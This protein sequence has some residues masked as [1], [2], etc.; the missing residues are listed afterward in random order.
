MKGCEGM[1]CDGAETEQSVTGGTERDGA[2]GT[3]SGV[4]GQR[5]RVWI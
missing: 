3:E 1:E 4:L 5:N 2:K